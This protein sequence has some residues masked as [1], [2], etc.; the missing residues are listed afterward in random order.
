[1]RAGRVRL[2]QRLQVSVEYELTVGLD[3]GAAEGEARGK[4]RQRQ[5]GGIVTFLE[6]GVEAAPVR[7]A[8]CDLRGT[9]LR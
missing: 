9:Q 7:V 1:M 5:A 6:Q 4:R 2:Q 8:V 3:R